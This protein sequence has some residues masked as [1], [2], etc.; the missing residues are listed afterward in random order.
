VTEAPTTR[1]AGGCA[2]VTGASRGIGAE[3]AVALAH[4][5]WPCAIN[6]RADSN[7]AGAVVERIRTAGGRA[8]AVEADV[9]DNAAVEGIFTALER[10]YGPVLCLVNN[11]AVR[12]DGL[13]MMLSDTEWSEVMSTNLDA[14]F[15]LSRR[16]LRGMVRAR[17]GRIVNISS[18]AGLRSSPGQANYAVAKAG[19]ISLTRTLA[20]EVARRGVTVNAVAPGLV[21]T[22]L[23]AD[24]DRSLVEHVPARRWG[25]PSEVAACVRFLASDDA[26]YVTGAVLPVDGGLT[27]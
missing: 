15:R 16:A 10:E 25:S 27:A 23:T 2:L 9:C 6:Y 19:V 8:T 24:V 21:E 20:V 7:G 4:D 22:Q 18:A 12:R 5:G 17:F 26:S 14:V 13:G 11:A 3:V 1:R